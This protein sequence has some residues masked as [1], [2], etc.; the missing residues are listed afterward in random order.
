MRSGVVVS[1]ILLVSVSLAA[2][3][4][5]TGKTVVRFRSNPR[6]VTVTEAELGV[7]GITPFDLTLKRKTALECTFSKD[8]YV[9][10]QASAVVDGLKMEV[11]VDLKPLPDATIRVT[12]EPRWADVR[13]TDVEGNELVDGDSGRRYTLRRN[14]WGFEP[15]AQFRLEITAPG[16]VTSDEIIELRR[17]EEHELSYVMKEVT[18]LLVVESAPEGVEVA[19]AF[20]GYLG[21]TPFE[22]TISLVDL[23][24]ARSGR[25]A[26]MEHPERLVLTFSKPGFKTMAEQFPLDFGQSLNTISVELSDGSASG[27]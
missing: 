23:M 16:Y 27:R 22:S 2:E 17:H 25:R 7:I 8:G 26:Q 18:T 5:A 10:G 6:G 9:D 19:D 21:R 12:V 24:R 14:A 3:A 1:T 15:T 20:L 4:L 13:L 11:R